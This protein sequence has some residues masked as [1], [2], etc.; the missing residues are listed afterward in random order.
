VYQRKDAVFN[1]FSLKRV[2]H[3]RE[4]EIPLKVTDNFEGYFYLERA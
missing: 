3:A 1:E 2:G 4:I